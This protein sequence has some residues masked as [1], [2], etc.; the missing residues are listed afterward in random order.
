MGS[1][2]GVA[3]FIMQPTGLRKTFI[4]QSASTVPVTCYFNPDF[5]NETPSRI[6]EIDG[7]YCQVYERRSR[8]EEAK[9]AV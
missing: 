2:Y 1:I 5:T 8:D 9:N 4:F 3:V 7:H 6:L